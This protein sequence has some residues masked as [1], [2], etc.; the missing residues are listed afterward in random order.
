VT[1]VSLT[2]AVTN[3]AADVGRPDRFI[4]NVMFHGTSPRPSCGRAR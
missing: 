4:Y 2:A 1:L 3:I